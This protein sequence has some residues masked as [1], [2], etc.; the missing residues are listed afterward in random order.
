MRAD[1]QPANLI[2]GSLSLSTPNHPIPTHHVAHPLGSPPTSVPAN[3]LAGDVPTIGW[4]YGHPEPTTKGVDVWKKLVD[5]MAYR[6]KERC[7]KDPLSEYI[8]GLL[9]PCRQTARNFD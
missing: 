5:A 7:E 4:W 8:A 2:P 9:A 1:R 6:W 3:T